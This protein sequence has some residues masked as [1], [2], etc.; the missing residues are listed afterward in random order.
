MKRDIKEIAPLK[1]KV[2]KLKLAAFDFETLNWSEAYMCGVMSDKEYVEFE[3]KESSSVIVE[4]KESALDLCNKVIDY[5]EH[6]LQNY[7]I[8]SHNGGR[9]DIL[10][11]LRALIKRPNLE[12]KFI[13][14]N[15]T[16]IAVIVTNKMSKQKFYLYDSYRIFQ[17]NLKDLGKS[18]NLPKLEIEYDLMQSL[19]KEEK[20]KYLYRDVEICYKACEYLQVA[21]EEIGNSFEPKIDFA[22]KPTAASTAMD[23]YRRGFLNNKIRI[24]MDNGNY[25]RPYYCGGRTEAFRLGNIGKTWIYDVNSMYP[26]VM[27]N[28]NYPVGESLYVEGESVRKFFN[29]CCNGEY[30]GFFKATVEIPKDMF[31]PPLPYKHSGKLLFPSGTLVGIWDAVELDYLD[32]NYP[33]SV[34]LEKGWIYSAKPLFREYVDTFYELK[35]R[36]GIYKIAAKLLLNSLYGKFAENDKKKSY[37]FNPDLLELE[38]KIL[39]E[40]GSSTINL[41]VPEL[42]IWSEMIVKVP[43]TCFVPISAHVTACARMHL[44]NLIRKYNPAYVDTDSLFLNKEI[45]G[46]DKLGDLKLEGIWENIYI[47]GPKLYCATGNLSPNLYPESEKV[48][49]KGFRKLTVNEFENLMNGEKIK[50]KAGLQQ[51]KTM[52]KNA[53]KAIKEGTMNSESE[54]ECYVMEVDKGIKSDYTKRLVLENGN[55]EPLIMTLE[56]SLEAWENDYEELKEFLAE[57]ILSKDMED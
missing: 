27:K 55:T 47:A 26:F 13:M 28:F 12:C 56:D 42:N 14:S 34:T 19:S 41:E 37:Y 29:E 53:K 5:F 9:F 16:I 44:Y 21:L 25:L 2:K 48:K 54:L 24:D 32:K 10:L 39:K 46:S 49:A 52:L 11:L 18:I 4:S 8:F 3:R 31:Y 15:T 35:S 45:E 43:K 30:V 20:S 50:T 40:R 33:G 23:V 1:T 7:V 51:F 57:N 36:G 38:R 17:C 6:N 22:L